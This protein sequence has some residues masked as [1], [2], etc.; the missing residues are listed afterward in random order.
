MVEYSKSEIKDSPKETEGNPKV[1]SLSKALKAALIIFVIF[2]VIQ[3]LS[4]DL[5]ID[6]DPSEV[7]SLKHVIGGYCLLG[8]CPG[9]F[10]GAVI[11]TCA[12]GEKRLKIA[13]IGGITAFL[14]I[15]FGFTCAY[16]SYFAD[17][18]YMSYYW[19]F[20]LFS[21]DNIKDALSSTMIWQDIIVYFLGTACASIAAYNLNVFADQSE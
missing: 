10:I 20:S 6:T 12:P 17:Q 15:A 3:Y 9:I 16:L 21:M 2:A 18:A 5:W 8:A 14:S 19:N 11:Y 4:G 1:A 7:I 13:A